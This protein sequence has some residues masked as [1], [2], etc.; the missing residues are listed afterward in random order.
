MKA[1][2]CTI[3]LKE[4]LE[5]LRVAAV[6]ATFVDSTEEIKKLQIAGAEYDKFHVMI[7]HLV[8]KEDN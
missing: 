3:R 4:I 1:K 2:D 5:E 8:V 7:D 6:K